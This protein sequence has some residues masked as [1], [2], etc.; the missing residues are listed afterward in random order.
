MGT[1]GK[2]TPR[3][4]GQLGGFTASLN[5][6]PEQRTARARHAAEVRWGNAKRVVKTAET[7]ESIMKKITEL[8]DK[9]ASRS[10]LDEGSV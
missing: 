1:T 2:A 4:S 9:I 10:H 8:R 3:E 5:M 6:T 7:D